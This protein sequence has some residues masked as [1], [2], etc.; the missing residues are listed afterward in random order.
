LRGVGRS[1]L[2]GLPA[3]LLLIGGA[4]A[5]GAGCGAG[6][7]ATPQ[8]LRLERAD[9]VA[10]SRALSGVRRP[11]AGELAA[12]KAAWPAVANGLPADTTTLSRPAIGTATVQAA[13]VPVPDL[14]EESES[15]SLTGPG[16]SIAALFRAY[17]GLSSRGWRMIGAAIEQIEHGSPAAASFARANVALY[18]ESVYDAHFSLAQ[19][20]KQL[21][22]GYQKL[23]GPDAFGASLTQAEVDG[24]ARTYSEE[25]DRLHP[26]PGVRLGS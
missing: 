15:A 25:T 11:V 20:G 13:A 8:E 23:G 9:L 22:A 6:Q 19:I 21:A 7:A 3:A 10:V 1:R 5:A 4:A 17:A 16:S 14:F 26:H 2:I 12:T 18:V 24:L